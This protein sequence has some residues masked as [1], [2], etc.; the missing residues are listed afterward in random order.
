M[1]AARAAFAQILLAHDTP[2]GSAAQ[3]EFWSQAQKRPGRVKRLSCARP[4]GSSAAVVQSKRI[5]KRTIPGG[6]MNRML[7]RA[8]LAALTLAV[9]FV[10]A[11]S[12]AAQDSTPQMKTYQ[13]V[14][15]RAAPHPPAG[16]VDTPE[17]QKAHVDR[18]VELTA[19]RVS[20]VSGPFLDDTDLRGI[21]VL[22]VPDAAAALKIFAED[23]YVKAGL[24]VAEVKPWLGPK[25]GFHP[26]SEPHELERFVFGFLMSGPNRNQSEAEAAEIQKGHLA[27]LAELGK[28]GK[29]V[30]A[31][32]FLDDSNW[33]GV[34]IYRVATVA[35]AQQLAAGD[36]AVKAGRLVLNAKPWMTFKGILR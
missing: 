19:Q 13:M 5:E 26:P 2:A 8:R 24:M 36:P 29:L 14:F 27:Y 31:G 18:L 11:P 17:M 20:L 32:P 4:N 23:A 22:D 3:R 10:P 25:D 35:E 16:T 15:L 33:R 30:L 7:W 6:T 34:V 9:A 21:V 12:R 28:Q 1:A